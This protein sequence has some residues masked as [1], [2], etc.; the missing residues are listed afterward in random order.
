MIAL[1]GMLPPV[2]DPIALRREGCAQDAG[3][4]PWL[5]PGALVRFYAS[6]TEALGAALVAARRATDGRRRVIVP[7]Y[8]CPAVVAAAK[9]AGCVPVPVDLEPDSPRLDAWQVARELSAGDVAAVIAVHFLGLPERTGVLAGPCARYGAKLIE[10]SAQAVPMGGTDTPADATIYSFGRGKPVSVMGGGAVVIRHGNLF[11]S[12]PAADESG[13]GRLARWRQ[14]LRVL[15]YNFAIRP[16]PFRLLEQLPGLDIGATRYRPLTRLEPVDRARLEL[17]DANFARYRG[18]GRTERR[19][20]ADRLGA[21]LHDLQ[22]APLV[23]LPSRTAGRQGDVRLLRYPLLLS[24]RHAR[25]VALTAMRRAGIGASSMY[26]TPLPEVENMPEPVRSAGPFPRARDFAERLLTLPSHDAVT[27]EHVRRMAHILERLTGTKLDTQ[28]PVVAN[29]A[30][31]YG[32]GGTSVAAGVR[33]APMLSRPGRP[34]D[35]S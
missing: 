25:D 34:L 27:D 13:I 14:G 2:G 8:T 3:R 18:D 7:A 23:D 31:R 4:P 24:D 30:S 15:A 16:V 20:A 19:A 28:K 29:D 12:L 10:D 32:Q 22:R 21:A 26:G 5:Q 35:R 11:C 33:P 6:G 1:R 9:W 17:L